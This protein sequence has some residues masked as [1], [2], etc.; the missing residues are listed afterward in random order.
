MCVF[1]ICF[2]F[3][4]QSAVSL[5]SVKRSAKPSL[6]LSLSLGVILFQLVFEYVIPLHPI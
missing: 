4:G 1:L 2:V 6:S 5:G 3:F